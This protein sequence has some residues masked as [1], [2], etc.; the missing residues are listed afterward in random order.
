MSDVEVLTWFERDRQ[1]VEIRHKRTEN[2]I[3]EW[4]DDEVTEMCEDGFFVCVWP[5]RAGANERRFKQSVLD[6]AVEMGALKRF[7]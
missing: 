3:M 5:L 6:Y 1:H 7:G 2:T 4:W